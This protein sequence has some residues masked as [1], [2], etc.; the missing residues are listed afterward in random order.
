MMVLDREFI[1]HGR[2]SMFLVADDV[3]GYGYTKTIRK[4]IDSLYT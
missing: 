2:L 3:Y 4:I 1:R